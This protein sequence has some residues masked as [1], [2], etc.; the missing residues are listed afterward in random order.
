MKETL[1]KNINIPFLIEEKVSVFWPSI[2]YA[3]EAIQTLEGG[4]VKGVN[5]F[6]RRLTV[7]IGHYPLKTPDSLR[8]RDGFA[9]ILKADRLLSDAW[10]ILKINKEH[11]VE[12]WEKIL[13]L[14][15]EASKLISDVYGIEASERQAEKVFLTPKAKSK[16]VRDW[17]EIEPFRLRSMYKQ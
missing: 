14:L 5:A 1:G 11:K 3:R 15:I 12:N 4:S 9:D 8:V 6:K 10:L 2:K 7:H 13:G 17:I 16:R